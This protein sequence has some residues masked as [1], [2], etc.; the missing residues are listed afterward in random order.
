MI[1]QSGKYE[2]FKNIGE[3]DCSTCPHVSRLG[4]GGSLLQL[5]C[6]TGSEVASRY[7]HD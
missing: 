5:T 1:F 4:G 3:F 7:A 6:S 2:N